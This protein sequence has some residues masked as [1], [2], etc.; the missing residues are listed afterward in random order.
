MK[1]YAFSGRMERLGGE[2]AFEVLRRAR[3]LEAQG[4]KIIHLQIGEPDFDTPLNIRE[5]AIQALKDGHTHYT[6]STG[7]LE[8]RQTVAKYISRTRKIEVTPENVVINPGG[9]PIIFHALLACVDHG[10]E[11]LYPNPG[12]PGYQSIISFAGG[13]PVPIPL[14]EEKD[15]RFD[16]DDLERKITPKTRMIILNSPGNPTGGILTYED[17]EKIAYLAKKHDLLVFSDEIYSRIIYEGEHHSIASFGGMPERTILLDGFSKT[18]AMTGWRL[19][20]GVMPKEIAERIIKLTLNSLSCVATFVQMAG[21]EA[22]E[23]PQDAVESMVEEFR[24]R[25]DFIVDGLNKIPGI[26]CRKPHGAFYVLPNVK[27]LGMK[28]KELEVYLMEEAGVACLAGAA[29]GQYGEGYM[30]LSY[31]NSMENLSKALSQI[32]EA[33]IKLPALQGTVCK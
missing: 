1:E 27:K 30:R 15:F 31:A 19:G 24:K 14:L 23:G 13:V 11:V 16:V 22:L 25:R 18:Y 26:S 7:I 21:I 17:L 20:Y 3:A 6:P 8:L 4:K 9:R 28:T 2:G 10:D 5:K 12:Y 32:K 29:F 33:V